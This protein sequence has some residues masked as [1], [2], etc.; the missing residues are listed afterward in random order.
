MG[1][2]S[3]S[4][5]TSALC[6]AARVS[7]A[8]KYNCFKCKDRGFF[9][10]DTDH[11]AAYPSGLFKS[12]PGKMEMHCDCGAVKKDPKDMPHTLPPGVS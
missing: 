8:T 11:D 7:V 1:I 10:V 6:H 2:I 9:Y 4:S 3:A 12:K 5:A